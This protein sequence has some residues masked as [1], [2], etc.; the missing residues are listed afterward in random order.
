MSNYF[1]FFIVIC[2]CKGASI[3]YNICVL[4][5]PEG[6][7]DESIDVSPPKKK[8][9]KKREAVPGRLTPDEYIKHT[10]RLQFFQIR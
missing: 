3:D 9:K 7:N 8:K 6:A 10:R 5:A 1:I 4:D 2:S